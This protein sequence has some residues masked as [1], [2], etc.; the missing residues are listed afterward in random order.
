MEFTQLG[1]TQ[2]EVI[3][4]RH[5]LN[6]G[7]LVLNLLMDTVFIEG[8]AEMATKLRKLIIEKNPSNDELLDE[9]Y[10]LLH[11]GK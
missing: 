2:R 4:Q 8:Q 9:I 7:T 5:A 1:A 11:G 6:D 10:T 3:L